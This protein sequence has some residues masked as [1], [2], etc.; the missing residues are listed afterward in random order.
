LNL[1]QIV[2]INHDTGQIE[3]LHVTDIKLINQQV[4]ITI[5]ALVNNKVSSQI[6]LNISY[7]VQNKD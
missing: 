2:K 1:D 7:L 4:Q 5:E 3:I 6:L